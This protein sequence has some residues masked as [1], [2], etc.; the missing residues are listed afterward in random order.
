MRLFSR[1]S[2]IGLDIGG[3]NVKAVQSVQTRGGRKLTACTRFARARADAPISS[4]ELA[5]VMAVLHRQGFSGNRVT[6]AA[7]E[8]LMSGTLELPPRR[9]EMPIEQIAKAEFARIHKCDLS[10]AEFSWWELPAPARA[11]K[12]THIMAVALSHAEAQQ[13]LE[14]FD[15]AGVNVCAID[16]AAS[17]LSRTCLAMC[18]TAR[19]F[20]VL[21]LGWRGAMLVLVRDGVVAYER[22]IL[23]GGLAKLQ[24]V[25][26]RQLGVDEAAVEQLVQQAGISGTVPDELGELASSARPLIAAHLDQIVEEIRKTCSYAQHQHPEAPLELLYLAGGG[27]LMPGIVEHF[28][29]A[30]GIVVRLAEPVIECEPRACRQQMTASHATAAGLSMFGN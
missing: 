9:A 11:A 29:A 28:A 4:G 15:S 21:D 13:Q 1:R 14:C 7:G 16:T 30:I 10:A 3:H 24:A 27:A 19:A 25:L 5:E 17:A 26:A 8:K 6:I 18:G 20:A 23:S 12:T 22:Q 2:T